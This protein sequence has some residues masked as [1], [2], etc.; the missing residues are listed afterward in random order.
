[1]KFFVTGVLTTFC[2][3]EYTLDA[4]TSEEA[5]EMA[6]DRAYSDAEDDFPSETEIEINGCFED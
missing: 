3:F 4:E 1:M 6:E 5:M 2:E